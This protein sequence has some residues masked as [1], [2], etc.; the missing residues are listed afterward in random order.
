M[1]LSFVKMALESENVWSLYF[2]PE[3]KI[4]Y[5][6]GQFVEITIPHDHD[7]RGKMHWFTIS[8]SPT[9][10]LIRITTRK[11]SGRS[12]SF[13]KQLFSLKPGDQV[14]SSSPMGDFVLPKDESI[15]LVFIAVGIGITPYISIIRYLEETDQIRN[16]Q[17][18]YR[19]KDTG[20]YPFKDV[21]ENYPGIK[22]TTTSEHLTVASINQLAEIKKSSLVYL[23]GPEEIVE[24]LTKDL[25][26]NPLPS[27]SI[28]TDYFPGYA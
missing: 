6:A 7:E 24:K 16:I 2:R 20:D 25:I 22:L 13:K 10:E 5:V 11:P 12:S 9:D 1:K 21:L 17:L 27:E 19:V 18:L 4:R 26:N 15:P 28:V 23:A 8:S 14:D 3:H